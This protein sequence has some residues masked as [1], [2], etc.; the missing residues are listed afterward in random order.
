[1]R[2]T[3]TVILS[4]LFTSVLLAQMPQADGSVRYGN[5]WIDYSSDYL[6]VPVATDG[7]Y[8]IS[9]A[10]LT[11]AGLPL[12][13]A[14][15]DRFVLHHN[16]EVVPIGVS[17]SGI[18]FVGEK[19]RGNMDRFL[20]EDPDNQQLNTRY[21][22]H[23]DT[24]A[25]FLSLADGGGLFYDASSPTGT[26]ETLNSVL[27]ESEVIYADNFSKEY[28]RSGRSSIYYSHYDEAEGFGTRDSGDLLSSDGSTVSTI[29]LNMPGSDGLKATLDLRFG[30]GFDFHRHRID[31]DGSEAV[32]IDTNAWT[33]LQPS[34]DFIPSGE[35]MTATLT[36]TAGARDKA[37]LAWANVTYTATLT[38]DEGMTSFIIPARAQPS[39]VTLTD[40]GAA[41]GAVEAYGAGNSALVSA[42][43]AGGSATL[44]FPSNSVD[45]RY[46]L[47]ISG[48]VTA[49][50]SSPFRFTSVVPTDFRTSYILLTSRRL[51]GSAVEDLAAYRRSAPGGSH[52]VQVVDVEDLYE[53]FGYGIGTHPMAIRNFLTLAK[54]VAPE[55]NYLFIIGKG[56]EFFELR[57]PEDFADAQ[58]TFF[59]PSFGFPASDNLLTAPTGSVVPVLATGRLT[60][61]NDGEVRIYYDKLVAVERQTSLGGQSI[62]DR[63]WMKSVMHLGG[64]T[65]PGEQASIRNGLNQIEQTIANSMF[66]ANVVSF[67][68]TSGEPIE[69][70]RTDAI[71]ERINNGI[72][73]ITFFGHSSTQGFD[74]SIDNPD[75]YNNKDKYPYMMSLGCYS[76]DGFTEA[77]SISERFIFLRDKGAIAFGAS[78]GVGYIS[79]LRTWADSLYTI[80]G[81]EYYGEGIGDAMR[82]NIESFSGTSNFTIAILLEQFALTGDPAYRLHPQPGP[83]LVIDPTSVRFEPDVVPAQE[84]EYTVNLDIINLGK[85]ALPDSIN[86]FIQQQ[87]PDGEMEDLLT[88]RMKIPNHR[89]A[90]SLQLPNLGI[91][92]IGQN[93][94]FMTIDNDGELMELPTPGAENNNQLVTG[95]SPGVPLTFI[96]NTAKVAY[97]PRFAVTTGQVELISSS[98]NAL[99]P[100]RDYVVEVATSKYFASPIVSETVN[101][102]GGIIR[103]T[104]SI[105]YVDS[106]TYYWR[107]SPDSTTT[108]GAGFIWSESDFTWLA[109]QPEDKVGWAMQHQGQTIDGE[110]TNLRGDALEEGWDF[111]QTIVDLS[112][113]NGFFVDRQLPRLEV[114]GGR[115]NSAFNWRTV[116]GINV[117]VIDSIDF[118][119]WLPNIGSGEYNSVPH[120]GLPQN[121]DAWAFNVATQA[122]RA[123]LMDF[124]ENGIE[125]GKYVLLYTSQRGSNT[126]YYNDGWL[127]DSTELGKTLFDVLEDQGA[128]QARGISSV[129]SVPYIFAF[130]KGLGRIGEAIALTP[131]DIIIM[132]A[133]LLAN[134]QEGSWSTGPVGP[135]SYWESVDISL[136]GEA[137]SEVDSVN[138]RIFGQSPTGIETMIRDEVLLVPGAPVPGN[139][140]VNFD[141]SDISATDY[142]TLRA[143]IEFFDEPD[144]SVP[145]IKY[146]YFNYGRPA[147]VA[148]NPQLTY[149]APDSLDQGQDF[150]LTVGY[151]NISLVDMDSLLVELQLISANNELT[152]YTQR[153]APIPAGGTDE[154]TF[155]VPT[156]AFSQ[157][158]RLQLRLNPERDQPEDVVFNNDLTTRLKIGKDVIDPN[159]RVYFDGRRINDGELVSAEP[160]ILIQLRDENTF[161]PLNDTSAYV[162]ELI[163]PTGQRER[164]HFADSRIEFLPATTSENVAEIYFRPTLPED[165]MY[166]LTVRAADRNNNIAGQL[167]FRQEFEIV[168]A[169]R[170]ANVLTYPNPFTTQTRF[171][172]TLTGSEPPAVFR[173]QI[174]TVSGRVVRDIDLLELEDVKIG[175]HQTDFAWDGTDEYGDLLANGV[176][177]YRVITSD[178][179]GSLLEKHDTG[180]DIYF[181][182]GLGKVVIL[183]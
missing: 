8:N 69:D 177:L 89:A 96:A 112:M 150:A 121:Q 181:K 3:F 41:A 152:S 162:M 39:Q 84:P 36:G 37:N 132:D 119:D 144:R 5:E 105:N 76:G 142:P 47:S 4:L 103:F 180:T 94:I 92:S 71:F 38:Y 170:V 102:P 85:G 31:I 178:A 66:G 30:L 95:G 13:T 155:T 123:G 116:R 136:T 57:S 106:T 124:I 90:L 46:Y 24:A 126:V 19:N 157:D 148:V 60:A 9:P 171:V 48:Q 81:N 145:T 99:A 182:N 35:S 33:V 73:I 151:E 125:T 93:R 50:E 15:E 51:H 88:H 174:M 166:A 77:R 16:G 29:D 14:N 118:S 44:T 25:Y 137:V 149:S 111:T 32:T 27:R 176:Y 2:H 156:S 134:W 80:M 161:L 78:K 109:D 75:N 34:L 68:K 1:M 160:E 100:A 129:G 45:Q 98:T 117:L 49:T 53:E 62:E 168:N 173:I 179:S 128:L 7:L 65:T 165:G 183:R 141:L 138:V 54:D 120:S 169:Q 163:F 22:M 158:L 91:P 6:R 122:S 147:D 139:Q 167:D 28:F 21:S 110:F 61:I 153:N 23:T 113:T 108:E 11:A 42:A 40:L 70:S 82:A 74:F 130:Q 172:Y 20:F 101:S 17:S 63:E 52:K 86:L 107:I 115:V 135:A 64:G 114:N 87:L 67:F 127:A 79:A 143:D 10:Q 104:P 72:S 58:A 146:V 164:L 55:L 133:A 175:T 18:V 154:I 26:P 140:S 131:E 56:R 43:S 59:V 12:T 159:L 83:D 97:P